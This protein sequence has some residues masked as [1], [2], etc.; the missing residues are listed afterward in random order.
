MGPYPVVQDGALCRVPTSGVSPP[1]TKHI[2]FSS[3]HLGV[4]RPSHAP[5]PGNIP[6]VPSSPSNHSVMSQGRWGYGNHMGPDLLLGVSVPDP[7]ACSASLP[8]T[9]E[10][11]RCAC[12]GPNARPAGCQIDHGGHICSFVPF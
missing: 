5:P 1:H 4:P 10:N 6:E 11:A 7:S 3:P 12:D 2:F 9:S 8:S